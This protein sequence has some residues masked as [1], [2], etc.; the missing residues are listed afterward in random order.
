V[1][2]KTAQ[3]ATVVQAFESKQQVV[4]KAYS[5]AWQRLPDP[6]VD[7]LCLY[8]NYF[9]VGAFAEIHKQALKMSRTRR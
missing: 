6:V 4:L 5:R 1:S 9:Q 8:T 3:R 7:S 2:G